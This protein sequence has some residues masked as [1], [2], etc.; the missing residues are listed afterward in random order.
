MFEATAQ[1]L[2]PVA[3]YIEKDF[4]VSIVLDIL[5]NGLSNDRPKILNYIDRCH[6]ICPSGRSIGVIPTASSSSRMRSLSA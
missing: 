2:D 4:W 3:T 6:L 1:E 5:Y